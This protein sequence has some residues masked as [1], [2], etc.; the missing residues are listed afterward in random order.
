MTHASDR[1]QDHPADAAPRRPI[2]WWPVPVILVLAVGGIVWV[3]QA[4]ERQHA[5]RN[6]GTAIIGLIAVLLL[7]LWWLFLSRL[8]W[9]IRL[10]VLGGV[11]GLIL[12]AMALLRIHGV[13]GD[14]VPVLQWRWEHP[15]LASLADRTKPIVSPAPAQRDQLTN[16]WPQ[17]LGPHRNSTVEQPELARDW[18]AQAPQ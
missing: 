11:V 3:W 10:E 8:R 6:I 16:N 13:T 18:K 2:C 12:L 4:Y 15:S 5:D 9:R 1:G 7:L 14:L 17:F